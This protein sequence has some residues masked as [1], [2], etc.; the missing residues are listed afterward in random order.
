MKPHRK[1]KIDSK[2]FSRLREIG[3][4]Y[5]KFLWTKFKRRIQIKRL[6]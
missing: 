6:K 3:Y 5:H 1:E 2:E 4:N